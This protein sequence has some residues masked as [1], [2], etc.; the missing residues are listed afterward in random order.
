MTVPR[1]LK[2]I[3]GLVATGSCVL[4]VS[5]EP[6]TVDLTLVAPW[7]APDLLIEIA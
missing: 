2:A 5:A 4:R 1:I 3:L 6:P 7:A